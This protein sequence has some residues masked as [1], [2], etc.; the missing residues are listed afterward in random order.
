MHRSARNLNDT[1]EDMLK[2]Q[3]PSSLSPSLSTL[4]PRG[5]HVLQFSVVFCQ[6]QSAHMQIISRTIYFFFKKKTNKNQVYMLSYLLLYR[7][8]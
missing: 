6:S 7:Y 5:I 1:K 4:L 8:T 2:S 3:F